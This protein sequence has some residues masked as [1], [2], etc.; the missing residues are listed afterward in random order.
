MPPPPNKKIG[1]V[2]TVLK[3]KV[4]ISPYRIKKNGDICFFEYQKRNL[5]LAAGDISNVNISSIPGN[6]ICV[7]APPKHPNADGIA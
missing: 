3:R 2:S 1:L 7:S 5:T 4:P 6:N